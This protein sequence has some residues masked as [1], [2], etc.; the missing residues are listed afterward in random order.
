PPP[1]AGGAPGRWGFIEGWPA[2]GFSPN[3]P[4]ISMRSC[5]RAISPIA[6]IT[7]CPFGDV[8][9]PEIFMGVLLRVVIA[10][11]AEARRSNLGQAFDG[12]RL[13]RFAR[14][15]DEL[16]QPPRFLG[17]HDRNAVADR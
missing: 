16:I 8:V 11:R 14:N 10:R 15:D 5:A 17:Q 7:F 1:P 3:G 9:R 13:L 4:P 6:H 12:L 2:P